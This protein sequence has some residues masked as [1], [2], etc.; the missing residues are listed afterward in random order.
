MVHA[1]A[2]IGSAGSQRMPGINVA[3]M[4]CETALWLSKNVPNIMTR[5]PYV[6]N[7]SA[8][9]FVNALS[10]S[11]SRFSASDVSRAFFSCLD[12]G[13]YLFKSWKSWVAVFL[14][15]VCENWAMAGGTLSL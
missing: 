11:F 7:I 14:S 1:A 3:Y 2:D 8:A 9:N 5:T 12:S 15:R 6:R 13:L 4:N 10:P